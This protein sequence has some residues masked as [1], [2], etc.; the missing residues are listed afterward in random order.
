MDYPF[1][2]CKTHGKSRGYII[3]PHAFAGTKPRFVRLATDQELGTIACDACTPDKTSEAR[4]IATFKTIC[5]R[6]AVNTGLLMP[7]D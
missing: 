6:C 1:L 3:C 4:A 5:E 7:V 2:D